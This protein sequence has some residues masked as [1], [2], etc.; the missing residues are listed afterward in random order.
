M[1]SLAYSA[2][3]SVSRCAPRAPS[4]DF[5][6]S[7]SAERQLHTMKCLAA[8]DKL[9]YLLTLPTNISAHSPFIICMLANVTIAHLSACRFVLEGQKRA[10]C[11]EKIRLTMGTLKRLSDYWTLGK[12]TYREL[13]IIAREILCLMD[14]TPAPAPEPRPPLDE[15]FSE[16]AVDLNSLGLLPGPDFDFCAFFDSSITGA[17]EETRL[18]V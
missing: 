13:G 2:I 16:G 14:N 6:C 11:R 7:N 1:S 9:E 3:E 15:R 17:M 12:R 5:N 8:I 10:Q 18:L 4:N